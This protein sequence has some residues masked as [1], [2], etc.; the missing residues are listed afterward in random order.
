MGPG[1]RREPRTGRPPPWEGGSR[2]GSRVPTK[3]AHGSAVPRTFVAF[4]STRTRS[5]TRRLS[6]PARHPPRPGGPRR[7][8]AGGEDD[9]E[10]SSIAS[11]PAGP[12][13]TFGAGEVKQETAGV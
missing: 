13:A 3:T 8:G 10:R 4:S 7:G 5:A 2:Y 9:L 11:N 6:P 12:R 1:S